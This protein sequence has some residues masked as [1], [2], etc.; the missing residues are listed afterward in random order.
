VNDMSIPEFQQVIKV[1]HGADSAL[2]RRERVVEVVDRSVVWEG[3]VLVFRLID[4]PRASRCYCWEVA[5]E[6]TA[7]LHDW[8]LKSPGDAVRAAVVG[9]NNPDA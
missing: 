6:V 1:I 7:V 4:H 9:G 3:E 8:L 5:G 2:E